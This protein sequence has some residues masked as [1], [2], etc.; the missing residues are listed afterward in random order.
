MT[1]ADGNCPDYL[2]RFDES[3]WPGRGLDSAGAFW[4]AREA[5]EAEHGVLADVDWRFPLPDAPFDP[6]SV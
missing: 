4:A 5:W 2:R 1:E 3:E 6:E